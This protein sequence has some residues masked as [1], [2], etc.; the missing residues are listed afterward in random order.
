MASYKENVWS[1]MYRNSFLCENNLISS[2]SM[3]FFS[4]HKRLTIVVGM[5]VSIAAILYFATKF[6]GQEAVPSIENDFS[7]PLPEQNAGGFTI[8]GEKNNLVQTKDFISSSPAINS[9]GDRILSEKSEYSITYINP[10]RQ[11][12]IAFNHVPS[13]E[14][15]QE[16]ETELIML[17]GVSEKDACLLDIHETVP[18]FEGVEYSGVNFG[19][20]SCPSGK[21]IPQ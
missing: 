14:T 1:V 21:S 9:Q 10:F 18:S 13:V 5:L 8:A 19:F 17:L 2:M 20:S 4:Q 16:A 11:F 6:S 15:R 7:R 12:F 3:A